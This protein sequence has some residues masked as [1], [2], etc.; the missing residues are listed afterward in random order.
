MT[1]KVKSL[2]FSLSPRRNRREKKMETAGSDFGSECYRSVQ[3][4]EAL[5][6]GKHR[7]GSGKL[8][9]GTIV[10]VMNIFS[11]LYPIG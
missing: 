9:V 11:S 3:Q 4:E 1:K 6:G 7:L 8:C 10:S 2:V 5:S